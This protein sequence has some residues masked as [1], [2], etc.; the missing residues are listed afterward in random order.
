CL[1]RQCNSPRDSDKVFIDV[2]IAEVQ[3]ESSV[4]SQNVPHSTKH[5]GQFLHVPFD[6]WL[7]S[8]LPFHSVVTQI[9]VRRRRDAGMD[10]LLRDHV[11]NLAGV[12]D[13]E[14]PCG[15]AIHLQLAPRLPHHEV[16]PTPTIQLSRLLSAWL[17]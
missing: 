6:G 8:D 1:Q 7:L 4:I 10:G 11:Y 12:A 13:V 14:G 16:P 2:R 3:P 15:T 9:P 5:L 17:D